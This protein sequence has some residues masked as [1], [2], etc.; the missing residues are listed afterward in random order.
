MSTPQGTGETLCSLMEIIRLAERVSS[1]IQ[2][3]LDRS[4]I[5]R[6]VK[7]CFEGSGYSAGMLLLTPDGSKVRLAGMSSLP[8]AS[9]EELIG[10]RLGEM[11]CDLGSEMLRQVLLEGKT[12][13]VSD[14][15]LIQNCF[16]RPIA[17]LILNARDYDHGSCIITPLFRQDRII[18]A[19]SISPASP[20]EYFIP[21]IK[22]LAHNISRALEAAE[23][24][25]ERVRTEQAL[26]ENEERY[27]SLFENSPISLWETDFSEVKRYIDRLVAAGITDI[28]SYLD[29]HPE[30]IS[31][32]LSLVRIVDVNRAT[33]DLYGASSLEDLDLHKIMTYDD[34]KQ[35]LAVIAE[36][37]TYFKS[38]RKNRTLS[39]EQIDISLSWIVDPVNKNYSRVFF[40]IIDITARKCMEKE[41]R[42]YSLH[43]KDLV[44]Q[45]TRELR[46]AERM[47]T[48]GET[49][50]MVSHDLRNPLQVIVNTLY[51]TRAITE[52][53]EMRSDARQR[54]TKLL[55]GLEKQ[56]DYM[57]K[58]V[59][60]LQDFSK[61]P[62]PRLVDASLPQLIS[63]II[64]T[65]NIPQNIRL[66]VTTEDGLPNLRMDPAMIKRVFIN[67]ITNAIQAMPNG[68]ELDIRLASSGGS[69]IARISDSGSGISEENFLKLFKPLFTTKPKGTGL[70]L[71]ACKRMIEAHNGSISAES[72]AGKGSSFTVRLPINPAAP[73]TAGPCPPQPAVPRLPAADAPGSVRRP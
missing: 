66:S 4:E 31:Y 58:I 35:E 26:R 27:R 25:A 38:E 1:R 65:A 10:G 2:S 9:I 15:E 12:L 62:A 69:I 45:K 29:S 70:G 37:R 40:S 67:L 11:E 46:D 6:L 59:S 21:P 13:Q 24:H 72:V 51:L 16:P 56:V 19:L 7:D 53:A 50:A 3:A 17:S 44:E 61:P 48:I 71:A 49:A 36:G 8:V 33:L 41:L 55:E 47:A 64:A 73:V 32:C 34:F 63:E 18:G 30:A 39:G 28:R 54:I 68:G 20:A 42:L 5:C 43:L 22:N 57:N 52:S 23:A 60:D 14:A